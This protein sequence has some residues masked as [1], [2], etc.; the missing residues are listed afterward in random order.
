MSNEEIGIDKAI[1]VG[2]TVITVTCEHCKKIVNQ[3]EYTESI[4]NAKY[5][6]PDS[7][8]CE[9]NGDNKVCIL[10][11]MNCGCGDFS[12]LKEYINLKGERH[13]HYGKMSLKTEGKVE[14]YTI[15]CDDKICFIK[16]K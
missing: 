4:S 11:C 6:I 14:Y 10:F 1:G 5:L 2:R 9:V 8:H 12:V 13:R 16:D 7:I 15:K 3:F